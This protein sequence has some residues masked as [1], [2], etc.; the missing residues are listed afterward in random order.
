MLEMCGQAEHDTAK[1]KRK[2]IILRY[3]NICQSDL[4]PLTSYFQ[5][6]KTTGIVKDP[7]SASYFHLC[8]FGSADKCTDPSELRNWILLYLLC[9]NQVVQALLSYFPKASSLNSSSRANPWTVDLPSPASYANT[10][11]RWRVLL[12][13]SA[14]ACVLYNHTPEEYLAHTE[15]YFIWNAKLLK[16]RIKTFLQDFIV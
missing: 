3:Q 16:T 13:G 6:T 15:S 12:N 5:S 4:F 8:H 7:L 9:I 14:F 2:I 10:N 1:K 11:P